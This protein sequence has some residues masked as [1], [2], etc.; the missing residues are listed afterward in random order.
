MDGLDVLEE[1]GRGQYGQVNK[2]RH[3]ETG[4]IMA[5]KVCRCNNCTFNNDI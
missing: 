4:K 1:L 2:M 3:K 5:V